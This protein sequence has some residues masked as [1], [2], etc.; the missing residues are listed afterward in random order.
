MAGLF[1]VVRLFIY[2]R[3]AQDKPEPAR[4]ILSEQ[5]EVMEKKLWWIIATPSM[6]LVLAAGITM[7]FINKPLLQMP[8][9]HIKLLFVAGLIVYHF[10][11][12]YKMKQMANGVFKWTSTQLR[13]WNELATLILFAIVFL[14]VLKN[15]LNWIFGVIGIIL[16]SLI[17]MSAVKVY[18]YFREKK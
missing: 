12:Q 5:F 18:K 3:E 9:L 11:C 4:T 7:V 10:I 17:L 1:Y 16:F 2:H 15:T 14:V 13:L 8:W 6:Y